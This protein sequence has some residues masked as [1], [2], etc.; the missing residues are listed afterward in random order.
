[1][2]DG[3]KPLRRVLCPLVS[4]GVAPPQGAG[5]QCFPVRPKRGH[6]ETKEGALVTF[7]P[8]VTTPQR[9]RDSSQSQSPLGVGALEQP[10]IPR[11]SRAGFERSQSRTNPRQG[12][13]GHAQHR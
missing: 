2:L 13:Q 6:W 4:E 3:G 1:M 11:G 9:H 8:L 12:G 7:A 5:T 10:Q